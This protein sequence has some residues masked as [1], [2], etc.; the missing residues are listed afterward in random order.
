M[1]IIPSPYERLYRSIPFSRAEYA[2]NPSYRQDVALGLMFNQ[3]PYSIN[4]S[5][6]PPSLPQYGYVTPYSYRNW[7]Q[8]WTW[9]GI[10]PYYPGP[11]G[12]GY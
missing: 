9:S 5:V 12:I 10:P 8:T 4:K 7:Y 6:G 3:F 11:A 1:N 2:A